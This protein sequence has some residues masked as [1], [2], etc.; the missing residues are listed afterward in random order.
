[1]MQRDLTEIRDA[2]MAMRRAA[3]PAPLR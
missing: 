1:M 2:A 3:P